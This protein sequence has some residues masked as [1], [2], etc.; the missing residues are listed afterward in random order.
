MHDSTGPCLTPSQYTPEKPDPRLRNHLP[1]QDTP[2][3]LINPRGTRAV[4]RLER[5]P[6][7]PTLA[8]PQTRRVAPLHQQQRPRAH[9]PTPT[10]SSDHTLPPRAAPSKA[11]RRLATA[12]RSQ[13]PSPT[14]HQPQ[15][16]SLFPNHRYHHRPSPTVRPSAEGLRGKA[17]T[18]RR[19]LTTLVG[20]EGRFVQA[21]AHVGRS[22]GCCMVT[23]GLFVCLQSVRW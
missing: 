17:K 21:T 16:A 22:A 3:S 6:A 15:H 20:A 18:W 4:V 8:N 5:N 23:S 11:A 12:D 14:R 2:P 9:A 1:P 10:P 19:D 7:R 13:A